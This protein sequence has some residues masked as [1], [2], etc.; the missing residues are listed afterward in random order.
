MIIGLEAK[1]TLF[2]NLGVLMVNISL[3]I[4]I[5]DKTHVEKH[6]VLGT[7]A[8]CPRLYWE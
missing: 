5:Y 4:D 7:E 1:I 6:C 8:I 2:F 3:I